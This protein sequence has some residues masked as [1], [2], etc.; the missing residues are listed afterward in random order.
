MYAMPQCG[1]NKDRKPRSLPHIDPIEPQIGGP[2]ESWLAA[3]LAKQGSRVNLYFTSFAILFGEEIADLH[4]LGIFW[5]SG[6]ERAERCL[7]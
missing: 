2:I 5:A 1:S 4:T 7:S 6:V 3:W